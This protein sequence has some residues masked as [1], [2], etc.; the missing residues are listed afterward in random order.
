M[1]EGF[2]WCLLWRLYRLYIEVDDDGLLII[3]QDYAG[4]QRINV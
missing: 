2:P 1:K 4:Q 3:T